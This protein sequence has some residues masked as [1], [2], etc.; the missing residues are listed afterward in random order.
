MKLPLGQ[1]VTINGMQMYYVA[2]GEG[3]P[4]VLL[5]GYTGSS[6]DW[7]LFLPD[8]AKEHRLIIPDLRGHGRSTNPSTT[9]T[10]RQ[11]A[12]DVFAL[13]DSLGIDRFKAIGMSGGGNTLLHM[14]TQQTSRITTM[15]LV[16]AASYYPVQARTFM[17]D[18]TID[19]LSD[20][21]WL[22]Q[23]QRHQHGDEQIRALYKHGEAF[24]DEYH[25]MNFI[26]PFLATIT[27][28][29]LIV[30]GDRDPLVPVQIAVEMFNA[31]PRSYLCIVPNGGHLPIFY[32]MKEPFIRII[33]PYLR[34]VWEQQ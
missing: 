32:D 20:E 5:H 23:R 1:T 7:E 34:G 22:V 31:I 14:A 11:A 2:Y 13:L 24:A 17:R 9:F 3:E 30:S 8:L 16:S 21:E 4:L 12:L 26:P 33:L 18:F 15:V 25:D 10:F 28:R 19:K 6:G 29:T 27:A